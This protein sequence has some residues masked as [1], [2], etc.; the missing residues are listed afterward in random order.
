M[1]AQ[2]PHAV[3]A[4][5]LIGGC[6]ILGAAAAGPIGMII[7]FFVGGNVAR[8]WRTAVTTKGGR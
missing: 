4:V 5:P 1:D 2:R 6:M 7:G 3:T 8:V